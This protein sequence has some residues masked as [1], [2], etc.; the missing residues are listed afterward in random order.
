MRYSEIFVLKNMLTSAKI[1]FVFVE[2]DDVLG[3]QIC[4]PG[5]PDKGKSCVCSVIE[6]QYSYGNEKDLLEIQGLLTSDEEKRE[7]DSVLGY[8]SAADVFERINQH[9]HH[10]KGQ[11]AT[12]ANGNL[13]VEKRLN[14]IP[15]IELSEHE[16]QLVEKDAIINFLKKELIK[17]TYC[18][19]VMKRRYMELKQKYEALKKRVGKNGETKSD[20][21]Y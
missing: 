9:Y 1:P 16:R 10:Q 7:N 5:Y 6:H 3:Y 4:Y 20:S 17:K 8:L 19:Q 11:G 12:L 2:R 18:R 21:A 13:V 14:E 15:Y